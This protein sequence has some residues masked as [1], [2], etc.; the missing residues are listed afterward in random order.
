MKEPTQCDRILNYMTTHGRI[1]DTI[2]RDQFGVRRLASR[3]CDLSRMGYRIEREDKTTLNRYGRKVAY[4]E[5]WIG[6]DVC[7]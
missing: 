5:Y 7:D 3:I 1:N 6:T 4:R 2:A